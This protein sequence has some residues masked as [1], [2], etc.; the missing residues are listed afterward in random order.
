MMKGAPARNGL[1]KGDATARWSGFAREKPVLGVKDGPIGVKRGQA[2]SKR[3]FSMRQT[4][5]RFGYQ[6]HHGRVLLQHH[7]AAAT[8]RRRLCFNSV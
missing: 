8:I 1:G 4:S 3:N 5:V 2:W 7:D 6:A